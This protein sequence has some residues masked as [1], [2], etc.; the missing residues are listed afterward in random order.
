MVEYPQ[1][2]TKVTGMAVDPNKDILLEEIQEHMD[3]IKAEGKH[4]WELVAMSRGPTGYTFFWKT[5]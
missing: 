1:W 2:K 5:I 3:S 4:G